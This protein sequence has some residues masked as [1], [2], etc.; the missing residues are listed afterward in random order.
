MVFA[1]GRVS[2]STRRKLASIA[3]AIVIF[4]ALAGLA[5][6]AL[7]RPM[8][9]GVSNA[10]LTGIGVGLFEEFY[11]QT[12]RGRWLRSM[13]PLR[14]ILVYTTI[15]VAIYLVALHITHLMLGHWYELPLIY[16]R[17]PLALPM[18]V[19][20]SVVGIVVMRVMHFIGAGNLFH[21][22]VGT[23][24][25]PIAK[26]AVLMF[27]DMNGSTAIAERLGAFKMSALVRKFL[28]DIA[29]PITDCGGEIYLYK[30]DGLIAVWEWNEAVR[31]N[32][33]LRAIDATFAAVERERAVYT[34]HF[35]VVPTFRVGMHGGDVVVSEQGDTKRSI[36]VYGDTINIAARMEDA[37]KVHAVAC[38]ISAD[39]AAALDNRSG[40]IR[41]L[42]EEII[43]GLKEPMLICEYRPAPA[44]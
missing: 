39:I 8:E 31:N 42:A 26:G 11:V 35:G 37:A 29:K 43:R 16:R 2:I 41:P 19:G 6:L 23:Y 28:F 3:Q 33:V 22:M 25:R 27:L 38:V 15:V 10:I 1:L 44:A 24:H 14:S 12:L 17:L 30:G 21:L 40:R 34:K 13:H 36:G 5:T 32:A 9:Y 20:F 7:G 18:F 4:A